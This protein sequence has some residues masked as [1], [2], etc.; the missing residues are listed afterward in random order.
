MKNFENIFSGEEVD[1]HQDITIIVWPPLKNGL[2]II[3]K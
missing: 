1:R 3:G 2:P